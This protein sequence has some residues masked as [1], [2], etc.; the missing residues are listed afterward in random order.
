[1]TILEQVTQ[2][3]K[4][5][6][7]DEEIVNR[8]QQQGI[9]PKQIN[10]ALSQTQIKS[11][12]TAE[13]LQ[14][15]QPSV[16]Q[17]EQTPAPYTPQT[18]EMPTQE[19][20]TQQGYTQ[21]QEYYP[22]EAYTDYSSATDTDTIM[23]IAEQVFSEKIQKTQKKLDSIEE[24]KVLA[25][26]KIENIQERLKRIETM[27]DKLQ[28]DILAKVGSYGQ[29]LQTAKKEMKMMQ[30]SLGKVIKKVGTKHPSLPIKHPSLPVKKHIKPIKK[31]SKKK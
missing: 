12:V 20:P 30:D 16:M 21:P 5:G 4:E 8:L 22:Q 3:K 6:V 1:M 28:I 26:T 23:E 10:D 2:L 24:F 9:T 11:A 18:Q 15:M 31:I 19:Y 7:A 25:Q 29:G 17:Q 13:P 27:I 14:G